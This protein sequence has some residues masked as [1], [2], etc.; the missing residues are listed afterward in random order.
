VESTY[1]F[2]IDLE[3]VRSMMPNGPSYRD[4]VTPSTQRY[5]HF[6]RQ[7]D[8]RCTFFTVGDVLRSHPDLVRQIVDDGHEIACHTDSHIP[9]DKLGEDGF[10]KDCEAWLASAR[11]LGINSVKGFRAPTFSLTER[12]PW[13]FSVLKDCGFTYSSSVL[14]AKNPL[15]GW[16][17]FG[18]TPREMDGILE[19]PMNLDAV[20]PLRVPFGGGIYF[21]VLPNPVIQF[22]FRRA[23][24]R[25]T[26]VLGYF[27]PYDIDLGQ[28]RFMHP[29]INDSR[30][31]NALM[32]MGR[33][34]VFPRL[35]SVLN[36]G[37]QIMRYDAFIARGC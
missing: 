3:D 31:Y 5:L 19:I 13:A 12:T 11:Q 37:Y 35:E 34:R 14:P 24:R 32:Y 22:M 30:F 26:T 33:N 9:L 18:Q 28:E 29:G 8:S 7:H 25:E 27:H 23:K 16:P 2:S 10:R 20:G 4:G 21:R 15:Y 36:M 6:L 1:L 17:G